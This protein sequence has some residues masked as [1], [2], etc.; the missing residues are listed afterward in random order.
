MTLRSWF[1]ANILAPDPHNSPTSL[2]IHNRPSLATIDWS[3]IPAIDGPRDDPWAHV[4]DPD[5]VNS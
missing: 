1:R 3:Y 5:R 2:D 4:Q